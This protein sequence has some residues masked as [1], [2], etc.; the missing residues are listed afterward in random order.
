MSGNDFLERMIEEAHA[1]SPL[2]GRNRM[3]FSTKLKDQIERAFTY[4]APAGDQQA[5]Y[6]EIRDDAKTLA[7]TFAKHCPESRELSSALT[8]LEEAV[9]HANASIAR[10][11]VGAEPSPRPAVPSPVDDVLR[12][13]IAHIEKLKDAIIWM[14]G[15]DDFSESG[16]CG[17]A[18]RRDVLPLIAKKA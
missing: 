1:G 8:R 2:L 18:F 10:S 4:H 5:R 13:A 11:G 14:S 16:R 17:V 12:D 9:M 7:Y 15:A 6:S 3:E